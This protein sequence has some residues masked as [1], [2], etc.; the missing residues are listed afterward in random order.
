MKL[1]KQKAAIMN[2]ESAMKA[3]EDDANVN[4]NATVEGDSN[5]N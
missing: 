3:A 5:A 4:G 1:L 2:T